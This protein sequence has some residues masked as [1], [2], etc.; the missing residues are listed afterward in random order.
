M[1]V[2][3][4]TLFAARNA[5][6]CAHKG[7][8]TRGAVALCQS[9][10]SVDGVTGSASS[11][12][13][14]VTKTAGNALKSLDGTIDNI[15]SKINKTDA[16]DDIVQSTGA[17]SKIGA[18]AQK[19]VNPLLCVAAGVRVLNDDDQ[20]AAL[21]EETSAMGAMFGAESLMKCARSSITGSSQA[22][23]GL[24]GAVAKTAGKS[25]TLTKAL[26]SAK[27]WFDNLATTSNGSAKQTLFKVG[28][29]VL[30]VGGSILAYNLGKN[31]GEKLSHRDNK[32]N[33]T[34]TSAA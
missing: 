5:D 10:S 4:S 17:N 19:A 12:F 1:G 18:L 7:E 33:N 15:F 27:S 29:D 6:K 34:A 20:Y 13:S 9:V 22:T 28:L 26:S 21:I 3:S 31:L 14:N 2:V 23:K 25:S 8:S 32:E 30:F 24:A 11:I 16:L